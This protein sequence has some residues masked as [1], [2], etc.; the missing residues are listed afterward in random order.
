MVSVF[1]FHIHC[2]FVVKLIPLSVAG[3]LV[4]VPTV[5]AEAALAAL[6]SAAPAAGDAGMPAAQ[7]EVRA[8]TGLDEVVNLIGRIVIR[9]DRSLQ[10]LQDLNS[11]S[12][13]VFHTGPKDKV[14]A[15]RKDWRDKKPETGPHPCGHSLRAMI[16]ASLIT[17]LKTAHS[18]HVSTLKAPP[19]EQP[20]IDKA[21]AQ[22]RAL[23][24]LSKQVL[25]DIETAFFRIQPK[26]ED[27]LPEEDP[28]WVWTLTL[29]RQAP[30]EF[31]KLLAQVADFGSKSKAIRLVHSRSEDGPQ[32]QQLQASVG[33]GKGKGGGGQTG[34]KRRRRGTD[35]EMLIEV[36]LHAPGPPPL[37]RAPRGR[38]EGPL[39]PRGPRAPRRHGPPPRA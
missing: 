27:P 35:Q 31:I 19:V 32:I 22:G 13:L 14:S 26:F 39:P 38:G 29:S 20:V 6:A 24:E 10:M 28:A 17:E 7:R 12:V 16:W 9:H 25:S 1:T 11:V 8:P 34:R 5:M 21:L 2:S 4:L 36:V 37:F 15:V 33:K 3:A 18:A 30:V 23:E